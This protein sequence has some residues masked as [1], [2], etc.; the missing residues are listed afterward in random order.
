MLPPSPFT[1]SEAFDDGVT[2]RQWRSLSVEGFVREVVPG[3]FVDASLPDT[4]ELRFAII[5]RAIT[6]EHV[7]IARRSA[8][9]LHGVDVLDY[10]GFPTTPRIETLTRER[11]NRPRIQVVQAHVADDLLPSDVA[12]IDGLRVTTPLRTAADLARFAPRS[13]ALV[14]LDAYLHKGLIRPDELKKSLVRWKQRRGIRQAYAMLEAADAA[15][16][17]GGESVM[18]LRL[19]DM[20]LPRPEVQIPV[21]DLFGNV[22][23]WL[24]MGW[25]RWMLGLEYDG[26]DAHPEERRAH[27]E[28]RRKWIESRGWTVRAFRR[29]DI[30]TRSR[31]FEDEV[32]ELVGERRWS[33]RT[34]M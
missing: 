6:T 3:F 18:R 24:D 23:F 10:R 14:A 16:E 20:G 4:L 1:R 30:F 26:E 29:E 13:D 7:V 9:W 22:R 5:K 31:K 25:T 8:S 11:R 15:S 17:S 2:E 32:R 34:A 33:R 12:E 21:Y 28:A 27:D 19:L